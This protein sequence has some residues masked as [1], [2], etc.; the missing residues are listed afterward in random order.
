MKLLLRF[1]KVAPNDQ[2]DY[3]F[4][5]AGQDKGYKGRFEG[6]AKNNPQLS[7]LI[8]MALKTFCDKLYRLSIPKDDG[9]KLTHIYTID[10]Y[11]YGDPYL[12]YLP[13]E[14]EYCPAV[15]RS[16]SGIV[17]DDVLDGKFRKES[18]V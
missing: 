9:S 2:K 18:N 8:F 4:R 1:K 6:K 16:A 12:Q 15:L 7:V 13:G 11:V 17:N 10:S 14:V 5:G 3:P